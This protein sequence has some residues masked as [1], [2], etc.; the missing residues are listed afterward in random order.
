M[1]N[2]IFSVGGFNNLN[3]NISPVSSQTM[4]SISSIIAIG[5]PIIDISADIEKEIMQKYGLKSGETI[6]ASPEIF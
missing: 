6:F 3:L 5:N 1:S 4:K 2:P